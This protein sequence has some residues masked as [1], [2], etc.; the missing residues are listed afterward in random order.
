MA[1]I[2]LI[3]EYQW[4]AFWRRFIRTRRSAQFYLTAFAG[5]GGGFVFVLPAWLS[6]AAIEL[7]AGQTTSMDAVLWLFCALWLF[8]LVEDLSVSLTSRQLRMFPIGV[9]RLLAVRILSIFCAPVAWL[10][11]VGSLVGLWPFLFARQTV[12]GSAAALLLF[13]L[14]LV[15]AMSV[16]PRLIE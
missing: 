12:L 2:A 7:P 4:R 16:S 6:R 11:A 13:A 14:A 3:V 9:G 10:V 15:S 1:G 8:V 5:I